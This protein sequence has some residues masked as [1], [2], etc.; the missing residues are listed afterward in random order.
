MEEIFKKAVI[1]EGI[2]ADGEHLA[3]INFDNNVALF[4][5]T[6]KNKWEATFKQCTLRK[7]ESWPKSTQVKVERHHKL[8][9][10]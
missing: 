5:E 3:N 10:Q 9:R 1:S 4:S 2:N 7:S 6:I 8:H